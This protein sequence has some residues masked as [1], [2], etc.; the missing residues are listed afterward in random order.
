MNNLYKE[1]IIEI[2]NQFE[3]KVIEYGR[4]Y[5]GYRTVTL[6]DK[7]IAKVKAI[8][9][10]QDGN[11]GLDPINELLVSL[12]N[13]AY[14]S[15]LV[16]DIR[17]VKLDYTSY[18]NECYNLFLIKDKSYNSAWL[19]QS[20]ESHIDEIHVKL[21]RLHHILKLNRVI[22]DNSLNN[23][24]HDIINYSFFYLLKLTQNGHISQCE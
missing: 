21:L 16:N 22:N 20:V 4:S 24:L 3:S 8:K 19:N 15:Y 23:E 14:M 1:L 11:E 12:I 17:L 7:M 18:L 2:N 13:Y 5:E 6:I 10:I 9:S